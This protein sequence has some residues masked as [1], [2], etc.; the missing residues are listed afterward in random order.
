MQPESILS[1]TGALVLMKPGVLV[2]GPWHKFDEA[3]HR[4]TS[5]H[6]GNVATMNKI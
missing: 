1:K 2:V 4:L 3:G 5:I 6:N